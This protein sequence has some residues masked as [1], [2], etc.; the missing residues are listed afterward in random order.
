MLTRL[1]CLPASFSFVPDDRHP[2]A[3]GS[4]AVV[5]GALFISICISISSLYI[6]IYI[7]ICVYI[8]IDIAN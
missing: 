5:V 2:L 7:H 6:Y 1:A 8:Y 4:W 3:G